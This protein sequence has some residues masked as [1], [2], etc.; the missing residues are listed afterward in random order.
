MSGTRLYM[1]WQGMKARC[2]NVHNASYHSYGGRGITICDEW[3]NSFESFM[4]WAYENGYD[5]SLTIDRKD[6]DGNYEPQN[7]Q[8]ATMKEQAN[9]RR[10]SIKITI[11][12]A[13]KTLS[14]WCEIF[15]VDFNTVNARYHAH[16][17]IGIDDL[18]NG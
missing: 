4:K 15:E 18:F 10:S 3:K 9:N 7:C 1:I 12:N 2:Y 13:T 6:N 16:G 14:E 8:W 11:G 17:F 5:D